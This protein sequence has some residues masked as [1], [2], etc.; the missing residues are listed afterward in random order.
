[1]KSSK[2]IFDGLL[3]LEYQKGNR[4]ALDVLVKRYQKDFYRFALWYTRDVE[5][6]QDIVQDGWTT[7]IKKLST[8]RN[9]NSFKSWALRIIIRKAQ[10]QFGKTARSKKF[11]DNY[12]QDTHVDMSTE[13][14]KLE[15]TKQLREAIN[16]LSFDQQMVIRLFYT[17]EHSLKEISVMLSISEGTVKSRLYHAREKLKS[18]LIKGNHEKRERK[19]R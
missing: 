9:P 16:K 11:K 14:E 4:E 15:K 13:E 8:L 7:I 18:I 10:D 12:R 2:K 6:A 1:M 3:V 17:E 5:L 19:N